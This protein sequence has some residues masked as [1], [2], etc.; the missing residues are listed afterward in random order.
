MSLYTHKTLRRWHI[1]SLALRT[2]IAALRHWFLIVI[3]VVVIH[4]IS[5]HVL[6]RYSYSQISSH[7]RIYSDCQYWGI[8]GLVRY[9]K[10][11]D[12]PLLLMIDRESFP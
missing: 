8:R 3:A 4:P 7:M 12:C 6:W 5:P 9:Q 11:N 10:D 2:I 1:L